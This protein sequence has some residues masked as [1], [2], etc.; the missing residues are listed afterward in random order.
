MNKV[1][2]D[3]NNIE[4]ESMRRPNVFDF[5]DYR[6][7]LKAYYEWHKGK[8]PLFSHAYFAK[9]AG[10]KSR[11]FLR[12]VL[13]GKRNLSPEGIS[14]FIVGLE[15]E[16]SEAKGFRLLVECNQ[17]LNS[18]QKKA[19]WDEFQKLLPRSKKYMRVHDEYRFLARLA[20]PIMMVIL[21]QE[22]VAH[23]LNGLS[24]MTGLSVAE[25]EEGLDTLQRLNMIKRHGK[26]VSV[27][28]TIFRT[29]NDI[30]NVAIQSF[31]KG[32]LEKAKAAVDL[33]VKEREFQ[34]VIIPLNQEEFLFLKKRV[35]ELAEEFDTTFGTRRDST[36]RVYALNMNLIPVS[37]EFIR[38]LSNASQNAQ[39]PNINKE[40]NL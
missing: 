17:G 24:H 30:P 34:S 3:L 33:D 28:D 6:A 12:L 15:I 27:G 2:T 31:H 1:A 19:A 13:S 4:S 11:S 20:Y 10:L 18:Q 26:L 14:K 39:E 9:K 36:E 7:Y 37:S 40:K 25:V 22:Q 16:S 38:P 32:M 5:T 35:R 23:D 8:N 21:R 29:S